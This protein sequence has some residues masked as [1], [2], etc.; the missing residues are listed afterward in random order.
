MGRRCSV[1][2]KKT[3]L[4]VLSSEEAGKSQAPLLFPRPAIPACLRSTTKSSKARNPI[5]DRSF[6]FLTFLS[7]FS[8]R[9]WSLHTTITAFHPHIP[10]LGVYS[11]PFGPSVLQPYKAGS[12]DGGCIP[13]TASS[14]ESSVHVHL[15]RFQLLEL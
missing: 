14:S 1:M 2:K 10:C 6:L 12:D 3:L 15:P 8:R 9:L 11:T 4:R 7:L 5:K 13:L